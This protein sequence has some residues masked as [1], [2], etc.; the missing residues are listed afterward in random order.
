MK[1][2]VWISSIHAKAKPG[3]VGAVTPVQG[4]GGE[5]MTTEPWSSSGLSQPMRSWE[6][7]EGE[8]KRGREEGREEGKRGGG[9][10]G[11][12]G[13]RETGKETEREGGRKE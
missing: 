7:K 9:S 1:S 13:G 3:G 10:E 8:K 6:G 4:L 12:R 5:R 2:W 11:E